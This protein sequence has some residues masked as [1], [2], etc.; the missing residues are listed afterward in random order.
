MSED[1]GSH[2]GLP[3]D[4]SVETPV[5]DQAQPQVATETPGVPAST[6]QPQQPQADQTATN[7]ANE[8]YQKRYQ[9]LAE[10]LNTEAPDLMQRYRAMGEPGRHTGQPLPQRDESGR[11]TKQH[12]PE[13]Q[14]AE[15]EDDED[16]DNLYSDPR[17]LA[18]FLAKQQQQTAAQLRKQMREEMEAE[19]QRAYQAQAQQS[20]TAEVQTVHG[21]YAQMVEGLPGDVV[22]QAWKNIADF[23]HDDKQIGGPS[24]NLTL[25]ARELKSVMGDRGWAQTQVQAA[26]QKAQQI[27]QAQLG[28]QPVQGQPASQPALS[29]DQRILQNLYAYQRGLPSDMLKGSAQ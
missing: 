2:F 5:V 28:S 1:N 14:V 15:F 27:K 22:E 21:R 4:E 26:A 16:I 23:C 19:Q 13:P 10:Y 12:E 3:A 8:F 24:R 11:F 6:D 18:R 29:D 7:T 9:N 20:Y 25:F 17:A